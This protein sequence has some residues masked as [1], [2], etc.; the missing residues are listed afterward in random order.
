[1]CIDVVARALLECW[2]LSA[3]G[4]GKAEGPSTQV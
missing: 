2:V 3:E 1:V 4:E